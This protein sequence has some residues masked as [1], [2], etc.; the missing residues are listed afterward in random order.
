MDA[1]AVAVGSVH[2]WLVS[3][4]IGSPEGSPQAG[5]RDVLDASNSSKTSAEKKFASPIEWKLW[6]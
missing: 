6:Q 1:R 5:R 3:A 2:G 4:A